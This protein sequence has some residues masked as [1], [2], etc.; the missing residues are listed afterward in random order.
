MKYIFALDPIVKRRT[1][2]VVKKGYAISM[3]SGHKFKFDSKKYD[4]QQKEHLNKLSASKQKE[5]MKNIKLHVEGMSV[6]ELNKMVVFIGFVSM[7][8]EHI[9]NSV[10][11]NKKKFQTS[12]GFLDLS[13]CKK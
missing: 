5:L 1:L 11:N 7:Y 9:R 12:Y 4:E 8:V 2:H 6:D 10:N 3:Q 13:R